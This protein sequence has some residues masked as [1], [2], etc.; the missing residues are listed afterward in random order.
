MKNGQLFNLVAPVK[1]WKQLFLG[2]AGRIKFAR[3][4]KSVN[5]SFD[6][7]YIPGYGKA[8]YDSRWGFN[9]Q[10]FYRIPFREKPPYKPKKIKEKSEPEGE[11]VD[12]ELQMEQQQS[13]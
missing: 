12:N 6:T 8:E 9:F 2:W 5:S 3:K 7:Y 10:I 1:V 13:F 4:V 11:P